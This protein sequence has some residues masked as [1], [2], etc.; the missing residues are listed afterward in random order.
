ME[1]SGK[2]Q[3]EYVYGSF[4]SIYIRP[5]LPHCLARALSGGHPPPPNFKIRKRSTNYKR[6]GNTALEFNLATLLALCYGTILSYACLGAEGQ[7]YTFRK[8]LGALKISVSPVFA[9]N[10]SSFTFSDWWFWKHPHVGHNVK[11]S[12]GN[13]RLGYSVCKLWLTA[14]NKWVMGNSDSS[15]TA[16]HNFF[17]TDACVK[18]ING[19]IVLHLEASI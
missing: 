7:I 13:C 17:L 4:I 12:I 6:L 8:W 15:W 18:I 19:W 1:A 2:T 11:C 14:R 3:W 16:C 9:L 5:C 10:S